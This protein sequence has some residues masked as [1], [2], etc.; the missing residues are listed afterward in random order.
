MTHTRQA[1]FQ[2]TA[3][4]VRERV[5]MA[6]RVDLERVFSE[7]HYFRFSVG[8]AIGSVGDL[9]VRDQL[10]RMARSLDDDFAELQAD[11][12][13]AWSRQPSW[14]NSSQSAPTPTTSGYSS[15]LTQREARPERF[16]E[17]HEADFQRGLPP[18]HE[19]CEDWSTDR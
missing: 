16:G 5:L 4:I 11:A 13:E 12:P 1:D 17:E 6:T 2:Q 15:H 10:E 8:K 18:I 9:S 7:F 3:S 14:A 19:V